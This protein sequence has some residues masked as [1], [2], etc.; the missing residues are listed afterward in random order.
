MVMSME[1]MDHRMDPLGR[2]SDET[3][4]AWPADEIRRVGRRAVDLIADY[5][6]ELPSGAVFRPVPPDLADAM[7]KAP[8]PEH[9]ESADAI[10]DRFATSVAPFPF[11]NGHPRFY[12]WVN[13][14]PAIVGVIAEALAATMNPSVAGGNHAAVWIERQVL[15]WFKALLGFPD[16]S[17]GLLVSGGSAAALTGL[18]VARHRACARQHWN[19]RA[20]GV[21]EHQHSSPGRLVVYK[22]PEGHA[23]HEKSV[24]LLGIGADNIR[25]VPHD[26]GM[27]MQVDELERM[28]A[29]DVGTENIPVAVIAS[30][31]TVSTG[32]IDPLDA[33]AD[34][35]ER[36]GVW[37]HVDAAYG[38]PAILTSSYRE[39]LAPLARADSIALDPHKWMYVPVDA[40]LVLVR[41]AALMRE[42]F[43][44]VPPYLRT[45][46]NL[47]GVQGPT[48]FAE[49]GPEQTRPF[50]ALKVWA[51]LRYF[52][53][54]GYREVIEHDLALA[55]HL[56]ACVRGADDFVLWEP[57]GLSI[58]C[59]RVS[60]AAVGGA[61]ADTLNGRILE[62]V[63]LGGMGFL[64]G[65]VIEKRFWLRACIVNPLATHEDVEAVFEAV[66]ATYTELAS[67]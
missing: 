9:G 20:R 40:A 27:R 8:I 41:D 46:G 32:A 16:D 2:T 13:S 21:Q 7:L 54:E 56:A 10:L 37:L 24:E 44:L 6:T 3:R 39:V 11:G 5:L 33:I 60:P 53:V 63:Q 35:C 65:T 30:A 48:W 17:M 36:Y 18:T 45:D 28:I 52:G 38:G 66:R 59:F 15:Q 19:V 55:R 51:A 31:G 58:V 14:P 1:C 61:E 50:R 42:S 4:F 67:H 34:V 22:S 25:R 57:T 49:Y 62:R 43:S 47:E 64:S 12:G 29:Q 23:C 26:R